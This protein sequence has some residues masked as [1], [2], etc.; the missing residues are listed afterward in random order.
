MM[1]WAIATIAAAQ[2]PTYKAAGEIGAVWSDCVIRQA[3]RIDDERETVTLIVQSAFELCKDKRAAYWSVMHDLYE[4]RLKQSD[5][6]ERATRFVNAQ[7]HEL[8]VAARAAILEHR[9]EGRG[10]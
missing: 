7:E 2:G 4:Q 6:I 1:L 9:A 3:K 10:R 5:P 8:A